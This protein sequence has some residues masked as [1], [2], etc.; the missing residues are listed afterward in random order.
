MS[1]SIVPYQSLSALDLSFPD[2][3]CGLKSKVITEIENAFKKGSIVDTKG[4]M[5]VRSDMLFRIWRT[6]KPTAKQLFLEVPEGRFRRDFGDHSYLRGCA[7]IQYIL[8]RRETAFGTQEKGL[9]YGLSALDH[10]Q[11]MPE[12]ENLK[13]KA[14][15]EWSSLKSTLK[16][17]RISI[18][19]VTKDELTNKKFYKSEFS[20]IISAASYPDIADKIWNGLIVN[21]ST[22]SNITARG[23][24]NH[25]ELY[26]LC[27]EM[28]WSTNWYDLFIQEY[29]QFS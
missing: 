1:G 14:V 16:D 25:N 12:V 8:Y 27:S 7:V 3:D 22:H 9:E 5:W 15:L 2:F 17:K 6:N 13:L 21:Q 23:I 4:V 18:Y 10:I 20:H 28:G 24:T 11:K 19:K 26:D 29:N